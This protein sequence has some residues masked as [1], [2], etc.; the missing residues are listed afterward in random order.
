MST[1]KDL[2]TG[3]FHIRLLQYTRMYTTPKEMKKLKDEDVMFFDM[4]DG[5]YSITWL[6]LK[7]KADEETLQFLER[8][9]VKL[10]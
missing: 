1:E 8:N 10:N 7:K 9:N 4:P 2:E 6:D 3:T 5:R